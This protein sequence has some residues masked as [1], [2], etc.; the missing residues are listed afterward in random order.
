MLASLTT[1]EV[2]SGRNVQMLVCCFQCLCSVAHVLKDLGV[3]LCILKCLPLEL[4]G[5]YGTINLL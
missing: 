3:G 4:N 1:Q 2:A 5:G